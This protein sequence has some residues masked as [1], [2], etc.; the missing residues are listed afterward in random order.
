MRDMNGWGWENIDQDL[1][2]FIRSI[3]RWGRIIIL[4]KEIKSQ[5][6]PFHRQLSS[7]PLSGIGEKDLTGWIRI[8][9]REEDPQ[10]DKFS[11]GFN[12]QLI[13]P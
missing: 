8:R 7:T 6:H 9:C 11:S 13:N 3:A 4:N 10:I 2:D 1:K 5:G 12:V